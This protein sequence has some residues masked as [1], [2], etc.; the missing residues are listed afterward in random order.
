MLFQS[1]KS[2][3]NTEFI[4][5]IDALP[6]GANFIAIDHSEFIYTADYSRDGSDLVIVGK[7]GRVVVV[8][9]YFEFP[10]PPDLKAPEGGMLR[11]E[12]V[13]LLAGPANPGAYAQT[14]EAGTTETGGASAIGQVE[15]L[16]GEATV[17]R[18]DGT[19]EPL[20]VGTK[21]FQNDVVQTA[22]GAALSITF[23]DGTIFT[24]SSN[25]RMVLNELVFTPDGNG[26]S[27]VFNLVEGTFVFIAGQVAKTGDMEITTP[28]AT[29]GIRGTTVKVDIQTINGISTVE[30]SLNRD[31][32]G[33]LG[34]FTIKNLDGEVIANVQTEQSKWL[35]AADGSSATE[36]ERSDIDLAQDLV[37]ITRAVQAYEAAQNRV[38]NQ[39]ETFVE[40]DDAGED[41]ANEEEDEETDDDADDE[42]EE[43]TDESAPEEGGNDENDNPDD[44]DD[45]P[46]DTNTENQQQGNLNS[47]PVGSGLSSDQTGTD[48]DTS[49]AGNEDTTEPDPAPQTQSTTTTQTT[50][51]TTTTEE[52]TQVVV[53]PP[54]I[55]L[56]TLTTSV[57]EDGS[58]QISGFD[59]SDPTGGSSITVTL[60]AG[61]TV[62]LVPGS[63]VTITSSDG[64]APEFKEVTF[65]GTVPQVLHALN[66][67]PGAPPPAGLT[68]APTPDDDDGGSLTIQAG[69]ESG[70]STAVLNIGIT[71]QP[72]D[73]EPLPDTLVVTESSGLHSNENLLLNDSDPDTNDT[74]TVTQVTENTGGNPTLTFGT[75]HTLA[76]GGKITVFANG[77]FEFDTNGAYEGLVLG[78]TVDHTLNYT[79]EDDTGRTANS[80]LVI[81]VT[82]END[83]PTA[84]PDAITRGENSSLFF[85]DLFLNDSDPDTGDTLTVTQVTENTGGNPVLTFGTAHTLASGG[86]ITIETN[87]LYAFDP[88]GAYE[89]LK[90]GQTVVHTL[91]YDI[92]DTDSLG[93]SATLTIT[94]TGE[95]DAP[96]ITGDQ[97]LA[98]NEGNAVTV[99]AA[100]LGEADPD[101]DG[102]E[103]TYTVTSGPANGTILVNGVAGSSFT[104]AQLD[105]NQVQYSHDGSETTSDSF[106][107]SLA[108]GGEDGATPDTATINVTVTPVNDAPVITGDLGLAVNE[109]NAV[110]VAAA[111]LGE[112]DPDDDGAGLTYTVTSGP[113]NGTILVNGVA[114]SSFTQAQ[115]DANQVQYSHDGSETTTD[116]FS[117]SLAD[118]GEDG[119]TPDT[120]TINVTVTPVNDAPVN[121]VPGAQ[122]VDEDNTLAITGLQIN[123]SDAGAN[124]I[125]V[126]LDVSNGIL[127]ISETV[128]GGLTM[129][130][131]IGNDSASVILVGTVAQINTTLAA[132][133]GITYTP[134]A[135]FNGNDTL[136]VQSNDNGNSGLGGGMLDTDN[137]AITVNAVNDPLVIS[138]VTNPAPV[139]EGTSPTLSNEEFVLA[140]FFT[141]TDD[142]AGETPTI[143]ETSI[144]LTPTANS[145]TTNHSSIVTFLTGNATKLVT[146]TA[147]FDFLGQG[148]IAEFDVTFDVNSGPDTEQVTITLQINGLN[149]APD[150]SAVSDPAATTEGDQGTVAL[151]TVDLSSLLTFTDRDQTDTATFDA[152][153]ITITP[154]GGSAVQTDLFF[155]LDGTNLIY[156]RGLFDFMNNGDQALFDV[157]FDIVSGTDTVSRTAVITVDGATDNA[158]NIVNGT[159]GSDGQL[160][161]TAGDDLI[162]GNGTGAN[163]YNGD[164][165]LGGSGNDILVGSDGNELFDGGDGDDTILTG[166][167]NPNVGDTIRGSTGN[168]RI[169]FGGVNQGFVDLHYAIAHR[170]YRG[171]LQ[172]RSQCRYYR[173][174]CV[175][176]RHSRRCDQTA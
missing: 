108:D 45:N 117:V 79:I 77:E 74:L 100:D 70:T 58:F 150:V 95:N 19:T 168:D 139:N 140:N 155:N 171:E 176:C 37:V 2:F 159:A 18:T 154:Q 54:K 33:G 112:A 47:G 50:T 28:V 48:L 12:V 173:Q 44:A 145:D 128:S 35:L 103:L 111:D 43:E 76:S 174:G 138:G 113:A 105:A 98:V 170:R 137:V 107:V 84:T 68:Y 142:D 64:S 104:Q 135:N 127:S 66:G 7:D 62:E 39:G 25:S 152:S 5:A 14:T 160:N 20:A 126:N 83:A 10:S 132:A 72:D 31:P 167:T 60:I 131:V 114:G 36:V 15:T 6:Q 56:P 23:A 94:I 89:A 97:A 24:L 147:N 57:T 55:T 123:D 90:P 4:N 151:E 82:G 101:D 158:I 120:A 110:T 146:D 85:G 9:H 13:E 93:D 148:Q 87:G 115:L 67:P 149:D 63:G 27:A 172:R 3:E 129:S 32:D 65:T 21:V 96:V 124:N 71:P 81:T 163:D 49:L 88:N 16:E 17:L 51:T 153:S 29:M 157:S 136:V 26:N 52:P 92:E 53:Q 119:A 164:E 133:G 162:F 46:Q 30:V 134:T 161:G 40:G 8:E 1:P 116:S 91:G 166:D 121:T 169:N 34:Q 143:D 109:G 38:I 99:A 80:T 144:V 78:Q 11:G 61:S 141:A 86:T 75:A 118:G 102:A 42:V 125:S 22:D 130:G 69:N 122:S 59:I 175:W 156:D 165:L 41:G 73:P 106:S